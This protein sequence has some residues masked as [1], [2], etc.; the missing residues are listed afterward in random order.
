MSDVQRLISSMNI[1]KRWSKT[2]VMTKPIARLLVVVLVKRVSTTCI[3]SKASLNQNLQSNPSGTP[4]T[5]ATPCHD[6]PFGQ[7]HPEAR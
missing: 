6:T 1:G 3:S 5:Q 2:K 7:G 4:P